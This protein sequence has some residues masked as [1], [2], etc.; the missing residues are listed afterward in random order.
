[1]LQKG[2]AKY[3]AMGVDYID[4]T[5]NFAANPNAQMAILISLFRQKN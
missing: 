1:M 5:F 2:V 4:Y 3:P